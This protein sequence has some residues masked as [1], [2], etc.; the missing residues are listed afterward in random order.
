MRYRYLALIVS[1][2]DADTVTAVIDLG[3]GISYKTKI[4]LYGIDAPEMRGSER[5]E[6]IEARDYLRELI[7]GKTIQIETIKDKK[8]KYGRYL[9]ILHDS[10]GN[11]NERLVKENYAIFKNY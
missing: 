8:G 1:V 4:R 10:D 9:G 7:L 5:E 11:I 2:Y 3:F 6:G